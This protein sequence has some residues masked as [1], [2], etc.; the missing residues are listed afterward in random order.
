MPSRAS[1]WTYR[2]PKSTRTTEG[3]NG[4]PKRVSIMRYLGGSVTMVLLLL[5]PNQTQIKSEDTC[6]LTVSPPTALPTPPPPPPPPPPPLNR[7]TN[8]FTRDLTRRLSASFARNLQKDQ[9]ER[10]DER[11]R[12]STERIGFNVCKNRYFRVPDYVPRVIV[13]VD[14]PERGHRIVQPEAVRV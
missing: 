1:T 8:T 2:P 13:V 7:H 10:I 6:P 5:P 4:K 9:I 3:I 14:G 12:L 11:Y